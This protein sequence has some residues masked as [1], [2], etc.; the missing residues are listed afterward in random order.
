MCARGAAG[1]CAPSGTLFEPFDITNVAEQG[2]QLPD[3]VT[4]E[5]VDPIRGDVDQGEQHETTLSQARVRNLQSRGVET[6][7]INKNDVKVER[8]RP[9]AFSTHAA[10]S[11]FGFKQ[12][13]EK[14]LR[15][16]PHLQE[17][18]AID[19]VRL[20]G[21]NGGTPVPMGSAGHGHAF[22]LI[23]RLQGLNQDR[24]AV[25]QVA[26]QGDGNSV[27]RWCLAMSRQG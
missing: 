23:Q 6:E 7:L 4:A 1:A 27:M 5:R 12:T 26:S 20:H 9:P 21:A 2:G 11:F 8:P 24:P 25:T 18:T 3:G 14:A 22:K 17:C 13:V 16:Q 19:V 10:E 15:C